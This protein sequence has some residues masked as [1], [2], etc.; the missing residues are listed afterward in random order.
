MSCLLV[1]MDHEETHSN[2]QKIHF[3]LGLCALS[4]MITPGSQK[5]NFES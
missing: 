4:I 5:K 3:I 2:Y 1:R